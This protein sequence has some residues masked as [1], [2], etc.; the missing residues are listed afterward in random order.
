MIK[1]T[2]KKKV[3]KEKIVEDVICNKCGSSLKTDC[4]Y[5]G[6]VEAKV[7]GGFYSKLGDLSVVSFSLCDDCLI[8]LFK[9]FSIKEEYIEQRPM[10]QL[11]D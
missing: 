6:L 3:I 11:I 10:E 9:T 8:E 2:T 1:Y 4:G 5:E 7:Y